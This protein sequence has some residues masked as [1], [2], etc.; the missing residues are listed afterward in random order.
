M[1]DI[2]LAKTPLPLAKLA[3]ADTATDGQVP[4]ADG[5][6]GV[7]WETPASDSGGG[8][9][10]TLVVDLGRSG[11]QSGVANATYTAISFDVENVDPEDW[12]SGTTNP[13][14]ATVP[15]GGDGSYLVSFAA[16]FSNPASGNLLV[17][18]IYKNGAQ[19][20]PPW[21]ATAGAAQAHVGT[22]SIPMDLVAG[23]YLELRVYQNSGANKDASEHCR[24]W[25]YRIGDTNPLA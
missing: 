17:A 24:L 10:M 19:L 18:R 22:M 21:A 9:G 5:A 1:A 3:G 6:G 8:G 4:T 15:V 23:D 7:A 14:R 2:P 25:I 11:V 16:G 12:H 13:T 20:N